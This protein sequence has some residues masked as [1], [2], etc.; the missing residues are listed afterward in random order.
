MPWCYGWPSSGLGYP[1]ATPN[2]ASYAGL[3]ACPYVGPPCW[4]LCRSL[5]LV[6]E[7]TMHEGPWAGTERELPRA[8]PMGSMRLPPRVAV[9]NPSASLCGGLAQQRSLLHSWRGHSQGSEKL[10]HK[11]SRKAGGD[12]GKSSSCQTHEAVRREAR[13][14]RAARLLA[15]RRAGPGFPTLRLVAQRFGIKSKVARFPGVSGR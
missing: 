4:S 9:P 2:A 5:N 10:S 6:T 8:G 15:S 14:R 13:G 11:V 7:T 1:E 3:H 12:E